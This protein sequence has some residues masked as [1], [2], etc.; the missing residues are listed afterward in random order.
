M[1]SY[2][3]PGADLL[4]ANIMRS[5]ETE[6]HSEALDSTGKRQSEPG[7]AAVAA[8][9]PPIVSIPVVH[10]RVD[11]Q[12]QMSSLV[13]R[14]FQAG[15]NEASGDLES[16][17][18]TSKGGGS[19]LAPEVRAFMEPRFGANFSAVRVHTGN[20]A[21]QMNRELG[22]QAFAHGSDVYFGAGK[23]PGNNELTAHELT[24]VVQQTGNLQAKQIKPQIQRQWSDA[25]SGGAQSSVTTPPTTGWNAAE[26]AI[27]Q[28]RRIPIQGLTQGNQDANSHNAA[29]EAANGRA[30]ALV[31]SNLD[32]SHPVEVLL[33]LHG[34]N[35]GYRQRRSGS[36]APGT[37]RDVEVD[38]IEQQL[39]ASGRLM[40]GVL[41]Q[42]TTT[43]GFGGKKFNSDAYIQEVLNTLAN[44]GVFGQ[45]ATAPQIRRVVLTGH[46]GAG[47][48]ISQMM[49]EKGQLRM[50]SN[51]GEVALFDAI[52]GDSQL[53]IVRRWV[54]AQ[55]NND[56][57]QLS[58]PGITSAAQLSY[59]SQS[60][61]FRAY[62]TVSQFYGPRHEQLRQAINRWF[63][64][65]APALGGISSPVYSGLRDNYQVINVGHGDH[66]AIMGKGDRLQNALGALPALPAPAPSSQPSPTPTPAAPS[67]SSPPPPANNLDGGVPPSI[68][69]AGA[70]DIH[71]VPDA[72]TVMPALQPKLQEGVSSLA[73]PL[74]QCD[75]PR[76][77]I[78]EGIIDDYRRYRGFPPAGVDDME[79]QI[80]P[81][82]AEIKY[83]PR[84][85]PPLSQA[86]IEQRLE[87]E[88]IRLANGQDSLLQPDY[89]QTALAGRSQNPALQSAFNNATQGVGQD[90]FDIQMGRIERAAISLMHMLE[91]QFI[92]DPNTSSLDLLPPSQRQRYRNFAWSRD[93]YAGGAP[94]ANEGRATQM[95]NDLNNLRPERRANSG[96]TAVVTRDEFDA[97][98]QR[99]VQSELRPIPDFPSS[100]QSGQPAPHQPS[101]H[102][103]NQHA[104]AGFLAMRADALNDNVALIVIASYRSPA[105][106]ASN[107]AQSGNPAAVASF[108]PHSL[109]LAVDLRMSFSTQTATG[110]TQAHSFA[111][112][113]TTPMQNVIDMRQSPAHKWLFLRGANYG[114]YPYQNEPWHW[115]YNPPGFRE[116]FRAGLQAGST[117][118]P[119]P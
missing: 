70:E 9:A 108:S 93:D 73:Y 107:A 24:H 23:S 119:R 60:L 103:L 110:A 47:G 72:S 36:N 86:Q 85:D 34:H 104:L 112:T 100:G 10:R 98:M 88:V 45:N 105:Q 96:A 84:T 39:Q 56:L 113:T 58:Q 4:T 66:D 57:S 2:S 38:R 92:N 27:G 67:Q 65:H 12:V 3:T 30:I 19:P 83:G 114:W 48:P 91:T 75:R 77:P 63:T 46:S 28:I 54:L 87:Q 74:I 26:V 82:D 64:Q 68:R 71:G 97:R 15:G 14:A 117:T 44:M 42:G 40:I 16:R 11:E 31:A 7:R 115:E 79:Q 29:V 55:L 13:Q 6:E 50:P 49:D 41:P 94:G 17:L 20:E 101:G 18:N 118:A 52:N 61:R 102:Q 89:V 69:D 78:H 8:T 80:G 21:V 35:I 43:S 1:P 51:L 90:L 32:P 111:E 81:T 62:H 22:A 53:D 37:V 33:H 25:A 99:Y 76:D 109:G 95:V 59:L 106:A 5:V 116:Q